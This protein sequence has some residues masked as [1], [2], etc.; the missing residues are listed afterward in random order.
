MSLQ[1]DAHADLLIWELHV[2]LSTHCH[3][4]QKCSNAAVSVVFAAIFGCQWLAG[5]WP[6]EVFN[7]PGFSQTSARFEIYQIVVAAATWEPT[8]S[9]HTVIFYTDNAATAKPINKG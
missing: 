6:P 8:W 2:Y 3:V 1:V 4:P 5:P 9:G 7:L